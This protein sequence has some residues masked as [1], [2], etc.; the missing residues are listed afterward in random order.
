MAQSIAEEPAPIRAT[1]LPSAEV[2]QAVPDAALSQRFINSHGWT[3]ADGAYSVKLSNTLNLW[4]FNDTFIGDIEKGARKELSL[5]HNSAA[6]QSLKTKNDPFRFF[7]EHDSTGPRAL[8]TPVKGGSS[9]Y[10]TG[11]SVM[12]NRHLAIFCKRVVNKPKGANDLTNFDWIGQDLILIDHPETEPPLWV[13]HHFPLPGGEM[14]IYPGAAC[15]VEDG[16]VYV[17]ATIHEPKLPQQHPLTLMR[18][19]TAALEAGDTKKFEYWCHKTTETGERLETMTWSPTPTIPAV[20][21]FDAAPEMSVCKIG[22]LRGYWAIYTEKGVGTRILA[23]QADHPEG[24]WSDPMLLY[25]TPECKADPK[26]FCYGAKAHPELAE[27]ERT[28]HITYSVNPGS[29]Y[30][31]TV[32]PFVYFPKAVKVTFRPR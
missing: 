6:W 14:S 15:L 12:L 31:H 1:P 25:E 13:S 16:M 21:F 3:G 4:L 8:L 2:V 20:L 23:R 10:W 22:G 29:L 9:H 32:K 24:P 7:W 18:I 11:D 5:I 30:Q 28:L 19:S 27:E 17:Y 26:L